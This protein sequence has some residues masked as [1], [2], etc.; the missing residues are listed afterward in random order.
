MM[1]QI[2]QHNIHS[3]QRCII[4]ARLRKTKSG[5]HQ[6]NL[7]DELKDILDEYS[8]ELY[9]NKEEAL[10][11]AADFLVDQLEANSPVSNQTETKHLKD[12]WLRTDK[13]TGVR[14]IGNSKTGSK[15]EQGYGIP[16]TNL[17]EFGKKGQPFIR[18]TFEQNKER[19]IDII[20]GGLEND[21]NSK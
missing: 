7:Y 18:K 3:Q 14:Y 2:I 10:D 15:N 17:L 19:I 21:G 5:K 9:A 16:L 13:Y 12:S 20:K 8:E 4:M 6:L 1:Q 11:A